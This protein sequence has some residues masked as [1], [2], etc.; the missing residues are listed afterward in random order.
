MK[1]RR[2]D[3]MALT[4]MAMTSLG[5]VEPV[6]LW[7]EYTLAVLRILED[8]DYLDIVKMEEGEG[9]LS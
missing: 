6:S 8:E 1:E 7:H 9:G 4:V 5:I 3:S 2:L